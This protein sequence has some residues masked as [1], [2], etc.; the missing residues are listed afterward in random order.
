MDSLTFLLPQFLTKLEEIESRLL[1]WGMVDG[2]FSDDEV[3]DLADDFLD[4]HETCTELESG[5]ELVDLLEERRLLFQFQQAGETRWRTRM[6]ESVRLLAR[7]R[8]LFPQHLATLRRWQIA[9]TLVADYRLILRPRQFPYRNV[10]FSRVV[11]EV[12]EIA[13]LDATQSAVLD[14]ML[15]SGGD[16]PF[17]LAD[18]QL[19][20]TR[21]VLAGANS[22]LLYTSPSP[23]RPY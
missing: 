8:Q 20:A 12:N 3:I 19:R 18:F 10:E 16:N 17:R 11:E 14:A 9:S 1:S 23:T 4:A 2:S 21:S 5:D 13:T 6:A 7:L 15:N 22:C